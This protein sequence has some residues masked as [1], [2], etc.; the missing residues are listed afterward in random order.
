LSQ[1][2]N[3]R[4]WYHCRIFVYSL[5]LN[6]KIFNPKVL[7]YTN[8]ILF[9]WQSNTYLYG[10]TH[11]NLTYHNQAIVFSDLMGEHMRSHIFLIKNHQYLIL[12]RCQE[13]YLT[14][15]GFTRFNGFNC[16]IVGLPFLLQPLCLQ[17]E[18]QSRSGCPWF[19]LN[20]QTPCNWEI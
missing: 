1:K 16:S 6:F 15:N 17:D 8:R 3:Q 18:H 19:T 5:G 4:L 7:C 2:Q 9:I 14:C 13:P 20:L 12:Q 10:R 11:T